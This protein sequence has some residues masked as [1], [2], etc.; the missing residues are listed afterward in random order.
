[1]F[2]HGFPP[3][4]STIKKLIWLKGSGIVGAAGE[5]WKTVSGAI[6]YIT[7]AL[8]SPLQKLEVTIASTTGVTGCNIWHTGTNICELSDTGI[9]TKSFYN[10][11]S[12]TITTGGTGASVSGTNPIAITNT[13]GWRGAVF[14]TKPLK[15]G[16][17][18]RVMYRIKGQ[19]NADVKRTIYLVDKNNNIVSKVTTSSSVDSDESLVLRYWVTAT[20]DDQ[21]VAFVVESKSTQTILIYDLAMNYP[22]TVD[23]YSAYTGTTYPISWQTEAGS[24]TSGTIEIAE[25]GGVT[26]TSGGNT[27]QL[28]S[29]TPITTLVGENNIWADCGDVEVTYLSDG[30]SDDL[31]A[32]ESMSLLMGGAYNRSPLGEGATDQEALN[33]IMGD[34]TER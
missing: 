7:D 31:N 15:N 6:V 28:A 18:C 24:I 34:D 19:V 17:T 5:V 2:E 10:L 32:A 16:Q 9:C 1:M 26:L 23:S 13:T 11:S 12:G 3:E 22:S 21:K 25:D 14:F 8:A 30:T 4:W 29:I 20:A 33:I 27:Y